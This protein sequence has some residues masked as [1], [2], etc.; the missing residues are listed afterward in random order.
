MSIVKRYE[1]NK[2]KLNEK[3]QT[4]YKTI[5]Y[6]AIDPSPNDIYVITT[7]DDR[8]DIIAHKYYKDVRYWWI[9]AQANNLGKGSLYIPPGSRLRIP[10]DVNKIL[11]DFEKINSNR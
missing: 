2:T 3:K 4:V 6:P 1:E 10:K 7:Q 11:K 8:L 9:I 5:L